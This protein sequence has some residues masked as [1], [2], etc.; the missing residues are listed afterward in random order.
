MLGAML[1]HPP[2]PHVLER[3]SPG[4]Q[5]PGALRPVRSEPSERPRVR[6]HVCLAVYMNSNAL[7][8]RLCFTRGSFLAM[9]YI[10]K[11]SK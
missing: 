11:T 9:M 7:E 5:G 6:L 1:L 8:R 10:F 2:T 4:G 3:E